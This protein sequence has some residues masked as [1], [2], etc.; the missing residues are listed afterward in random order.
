MNSNYWIGN[1]QL[2]LL[3]SG[4]QYRL[5]VDVQT[6]AN[7]QWYWAEYS[8]FR[9]GSEATRYRL[10]IGG[11]SGTAGDAM[12]STSWGNLNG[13]M[14]TTLDSENDNCYDCN[15]AVTPSAGYPC[16]GG[17]WYNSCGD[18]LINTPSNCTGPL[19]GFQWRVLPTAD[20][21]LLYTRLALI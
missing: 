7:C 4:G 10:T 6:R 11:Y 17:F 2:N 9:V 18:A 14:F 5:R 12:T 13:M 1:D 16:G 3:T 20:T 8:T 19:S 15:C 21:K